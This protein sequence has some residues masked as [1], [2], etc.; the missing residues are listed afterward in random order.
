MWH[1]AAEAHTNSRRPASKDANRNSSRRIEVSRPSRVVRQSETAGHRPDAF[2][3]AIN[4][5]SF[6]LRAEHPTAT[7]IGFWAKVC[8]MQF[9]EYQRMCKLDARFYKRKYFMA[10]RSFRVPITLPSGRQIVI[11]GKMDGGYTRSGK[12]WLKEIKCK[13]DIDQIGIMQTI[14]RN[15]QC[16][17]YYIAGLNSPD[18]PPLHGIGYHVIRRPLG[19]RFA[20]RQKKSESE[21]A[22][23]RRIR[24]DIR[25]KPNNYFFLWEVPIKQSVV[26]R[27]LIEVYYPLMEQVL[28][29]WDWISADGFADPFRYGWI[30][31]HWAHAADVPNVGIPGGGVHWQSPW[32]CYS[33]L[34]NGYRGDYFDY[35]TIGRRHGLVPVRS[36]FSELEDI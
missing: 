35:L 6:N 12:N 28:D 19:D 11:R 33:S 34:A 2:V 25:A 8:R 36:L 20:L 27:F 17:N 31:P 9:E 22:F 21:D 26:D 4:K 15:L 24:D 5:M 3:Q 1:A 7:K 29:W 16:M 10:E 32:G 18:I 30:V 23:I 14:T 13:G